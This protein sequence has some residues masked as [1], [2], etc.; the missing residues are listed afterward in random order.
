MSGEET[1]TNLPEDAMLLVNRLCNQFE[2]A[3]QSGKCPR[4][5]EWIAELDARW[6]RPALR[7]LLPLE[8]EYRR[9]AGEAIAAREYVER[10]P[11][12]DAAWLGRLCEPATQAA[13]PPSKEIAQQPRAAPAPTAKIKR[14]GDYDLIAK[15]GAGGMGTVYKAVH[16][17][18]HRVVALK[19]LR[20]GMQSNPQL[21]A[22]FEREVRTAAQLSH[23]NIVTA[24]DA[25]EDRGLHYLITE[26]VDGDDLE[27]VVQ[28]Q[29]PL[30]A[31]RAIRYLLQAARGLAYAHS[32]QVIHRDIKPANLLL[33]RNGVVKIL[34][35]GL[36]R[37]SAEDQTSS[38]PEG[39]LTESG[40]IMGTAAYMA[41]EQARSTRNADERADIYS[42]GC[43]L[44]YLLTGKPVYL[45]ETAIDLLV[46]HARE[47]IP[48]LAADGSGE[49]IAK[50]LQD[51]FQRMVA[52]QPSDRF[53][54]MADVVEELEKLAQQAPTWIA[55]LG[56]PTL[57]NKA[58][59]PVPRQMPQRRRPRVWPTFAVA[60]GALALLAALG[61]WL[62]RGPDDASLST[63]L[64]DSRLTVNAN[65]TTV[66]SSSDASRY[67]LSFN[68]Q[69]SY[70]AAP[71]LTLDP[72][73]P[74]TIEA[75]VQVRTPR[76]SNVVSWLG[77]D[78]IALFQS[79]EGNWGIGR[80]LGEGSRLYLAD[81][82]TSPEEWR[83]LAATAAHGDLALF[84]DGQRV[85]V[86]AVEFSLP[87]TAGGL[88]IGGVR[89]DLLPAGQ[90]D[91]FFDGLID[92]VRISRGI[93]YRESFAAP[94]ALIN[95]E[96]TLALFSL[97]VGTGDIAPD[98]SGR[99]HRGVIVNAQWMPRR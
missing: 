51:L 22:R 98:D 13:L 84:V 62:T 2:Q 39:N 8:I 34:D 89:R 72:A 71:S 83:H 80:R 60:V 92:C 42:L 68:G 75:I 33:D 79:G 88:Y 59:V 31:E 5:E 44:H 57:V 52:K 41:P 4:A 50:G 28:Q 70:I 9:R 74:V 23:P 82:P 76:V 1:F 93:R 25:R 14:L 85:A 47:P 38:A 94:R 32:Q 40:M 91:R 87:E 95:D 15:V 20:A 81:E 96:Q 10:H 35:M 43:T 78:W 49:P 86:H 3:W 11:E 19:V 37:Q 54:H 36:A 61:A 46:A 16:R 90:N 26:F 27:R 64:D 97:E 6:R 21:L 99:N 63:P 30:P 17:R 77:P 73:M 18:M 65:T 67:A 7:E 56:F 53:P 58:S 45:G 24:Y 29:G 12:L 66:L 69:D 55:P 48:V